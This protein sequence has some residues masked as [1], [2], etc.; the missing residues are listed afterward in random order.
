[1]AMA[2]RVESGRGSGLFQALGRVGANVGCW[3]SPYSKSISIMQYLVEA[4]V[5]TKPFSFGAYGFPM[6]KRLRLAP[7][8]GFQQVFC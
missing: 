4:G 6:L 7:D 3:I 8:M 2:M 5:G 1:M